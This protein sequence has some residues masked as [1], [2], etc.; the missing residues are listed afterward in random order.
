MIGDPFDE[1]TSHGPQVSQQQYDRVMSYVEQGKAEG[2]TLVAGGSTPGGNFVAPT[3]FKDVEDHHSI[4]QEEV[5]GPFVVFA[6]FKTQ[7]EAI[8]RANATKY[9]LGAAIFTRDLKRAHKVAR[10]VESGMVW[11]NS[12]NDSHLAVPFGYLQKFL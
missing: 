9:G 4:F 3:I 8:K 1:S 6:K 11:I 7:D 12:S 5:F 2:A 10:K